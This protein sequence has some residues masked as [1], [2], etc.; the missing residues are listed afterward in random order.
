MSSGLEL[1]QSH[2]SFGKNVQGEAYATWAQELLQVHLWWQN[3][4]ARGDRLVVPILATARQDFANLT[5]SYDATL[6]MA[7]VA[8]LPFGTPHVQPIGLQWPSHA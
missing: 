2:S 5:G 1:S 6:S 8:E 3:E 7:R 4:Q